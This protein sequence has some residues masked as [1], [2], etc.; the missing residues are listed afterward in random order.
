MKKQKIQYLELWKKFQKEEVK[1]KKDKLR[2]EL[3]ELYYPLV[4]KISYKIAKKFINLV[5]DDLGL[6]P[7]S[8]RNNWFSSFW[9]IP[10]QH[11]Y[12]VIQLLQNT[13]KN[14]N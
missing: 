4:Q 1:I 10:T 7:L 3:V 8:I 5:A 13:I 14:Q 9:A 2:K 11:E 12:R 6:K